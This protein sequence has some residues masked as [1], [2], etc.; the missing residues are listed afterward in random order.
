[1]K[2][3]ILSILS[4][5]CVRYFL[6]SSLYVAELVEIMA[7]IEQVVMQKVKTL[8]SDKIELPSKNQSFLYSVY[9]CSNSKGSHQVRHK[10]I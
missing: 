9:C 2:T 5:L 8:A 7:K 10:T 4:V 1:M 3:T 6:M